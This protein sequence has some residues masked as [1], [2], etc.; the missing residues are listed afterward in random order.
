MRP[1]ECVEIIEWAAALAA[2]VFVA[3]LLPRHCLDD[4]IFK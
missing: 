4:S 2:V 1:A 3:A